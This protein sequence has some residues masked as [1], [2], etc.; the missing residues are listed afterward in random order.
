[1]GE[2]FKK[3]QFEAKIGN[4]IIFTGGQKDVLAVCRDDFQCASITSC[5]SYEDGY[6]CNFVFSLYKEH[7]LNLF[8]KKIKL[9]VLN[10]LFDKIVLNI[11]IYT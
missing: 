10:Y 2:L 6:Y 7:K 5:N 4:E 11:Q 3:G 9:Q 1:M 8:Q